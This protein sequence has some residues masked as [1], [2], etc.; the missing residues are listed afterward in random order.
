MR[1]DFCINVF[2]KTKPQ[3]LYFVVQNIYKNILKKMWILRYFSY[4]TYKEILE[5]VI[6]LTYARHRTQLA[7]AEHIP[8]CS[9][10]CISLQV[11]YSGLKK[12][13]LF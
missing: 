6:T 11:S 3:A 12:V 7:S 9:Q 13:T 4:A 5:T 8:N 1:R 2:W 10:S